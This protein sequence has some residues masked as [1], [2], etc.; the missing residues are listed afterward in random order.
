MQYSNNAGSQ[1]CNLYV[2]NI[3]H[4]SCISACKSTIKE[5]IITHKFTSY[6][7]TLQ[8]SFSYYF[9]LL[10]LLDKPWN[11]MQNIYLQ[12]SIYHQRTIDSPLDLGITKLSINTDMMAYI[13]NT[14]RLTSIQSVYPVP[15]QTVSVGSIKY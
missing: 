14:T 13:Q 9:L 2:D 3:M 7:F 11:Y 1:S 15:G 12:N 10:H 4:A 8:Y 6:L 5:R